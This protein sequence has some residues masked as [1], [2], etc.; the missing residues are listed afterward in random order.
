MHEMRKAFCLALARAGRSKAAKIAM[1]AMT[2]SSS[3]N[4]NARGD[5]TVFFLNINP[6]LGQHLTAAWFRPLETVV[7]NIMQI[8]FELIRGTLGV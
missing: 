6:A 2:T 7:S 3:I 8:T 4:V 1:M 5:R